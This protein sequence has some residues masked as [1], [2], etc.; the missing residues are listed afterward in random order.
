[1]SFFFW[2]LD[3]D[4]DEM[5][6]GRGGGGRLQLKVCRIKPVNCIYKICSSKAAQ[7]SIHINYAGPHQA[8]NDKVLIYFY[9]CLQLTN[10]YKNKSRY[11]E[12]DNKSSICYFKVYIDVICTWNILTTSSY[13]QTGKAIFY[14]IK[15]K[16]HLFYVVICRHGIGKKIGMF[17]RYT[18]AGGFRLISPL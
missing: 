15:V 8:W 17:Y 12:S 2:K 1:M 9:H 11:S 4:R 14:L 16:V 6:G 13:C 3:R 5:R 7:T 10:L 18:L